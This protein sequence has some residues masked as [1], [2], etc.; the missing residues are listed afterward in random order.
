VATKPGSEAGVLTIIA[1][2]LA[3]LVGSVELAIIFLF[4]GL[5]VVLIKGGWKALELPWPPPPP[6]QPRTPRYRPPRPPIPDAV[7]GHGM[8]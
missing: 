1:V 2:V 5:K 3:V 7:K 4:V 8:A 6:A